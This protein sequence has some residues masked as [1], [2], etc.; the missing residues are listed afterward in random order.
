[1]SSYLVAIVVGEFD[2]IEDK[3]SDGVLVRVYT[4][5]NKKE[6]GTFAL[7]VAIKVLPYYKDYFNIGFP[8]PKLDLIAI[9]DLACGAMENCRFKK[10]G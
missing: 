2:Y 7:D 8:L 3:S 9:A 1:M 10:K 5:L 4:P 6:Q